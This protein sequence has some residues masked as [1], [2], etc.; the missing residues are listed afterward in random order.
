M[1]LLAMCLY[2]DAEA[3]RALTFS[4]AARNTGSAALFVGTASAWCRTGAKAGEGI[5]QMPD[6]YMRHRLW[7]FEA[8]SVYELTGSWRHHDHLVCFLQ[9]VGFLHQ[10][11]SL[12]CAMHRPAGPPCAMHVQECLLAVAA[13]G[14]PDSS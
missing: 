8:G 11:V 2:E 10:H 7:C 14:R 9:L 5:S 6:A 13:T 3:T 4:A 12:A 1:M